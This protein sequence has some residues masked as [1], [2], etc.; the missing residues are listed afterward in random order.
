M[1]KDIITTKD[2]FVSENNILTKKSDNISTIRLI[3][4]FDAHFIEG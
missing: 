1:K 3:L 4:F 2:L